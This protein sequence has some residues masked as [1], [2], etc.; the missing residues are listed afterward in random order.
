MKL[1]KFTADWCGPC[2]AMV[3]AGTMEKVTEQTG[4]RVTELNIEVGENR[5]TATAYNVLSIPT[6]VLL[7]DSGNELGRIVG[8][9]GVTEYVE[10][11]NLH[12][13]D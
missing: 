11:V 4:V 6:V 7:D 8:A 1:V 12:K 2:K 3:K 5:S 13:K 10:F 9:K